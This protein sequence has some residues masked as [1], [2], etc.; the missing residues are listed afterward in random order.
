MFSFE[1]HI[2][3]SRAGLASNATTDRHHYRILLFP[4]R[5]VCYARGLPINQTDLTTGG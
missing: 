2:K 4:W 1:P 3:K 5:H